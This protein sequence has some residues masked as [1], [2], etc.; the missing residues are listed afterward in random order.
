MLVS[1]QAR[2]KYATALHIAGGLAFAC[3]ERVSPV[4][5]QTTG[6][7]DYQVEPSLSKDQILQWLHHLRRYT[8]NQQSILGTRL[9]QLCGRL[10]NRTLII[11]ISDMHEPAALNALK[12]AAQLHDIAVIQLRD[13]GERELSGNWH[14]SRVGNRKPVENSSPMEVA[15]GQIHPSLTKS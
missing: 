9:S 1:N 4:G 3:L 10:K 14:F 7:D 12:I 6:S 13:P 5:I 8:M 2:N 15:N 11:V